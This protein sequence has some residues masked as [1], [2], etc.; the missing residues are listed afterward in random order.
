M[1]A[2]VYDLYISYPDARPSA[3]ESR[4]QAMVVRIDPADR[5]PEGARLLSRCS[6][7]AL[8]CMPSAPDLLHSNPDG[9]GVDRDRIVEPLL[10]AREAVVGI[11]AR[12]RSERPWSPHAELAPAPPAPELKQSRAPAMRLPALLENMGLCAAQALPVRGDL[13][14]VTVAVIDRDFACLERVANPRL[15]ALTLI[16]LERS[17]PAPANTQYIGHGTAMVLSLLEASACRV[18]PYQVG[19][20]ADASYD[21]LG[22]T[23][24]TMA[25]A[26]ACE[27]G[28]DLI[29]IAKNWT[30]LGS[31]RH[32]RRVMQEVSRA[33]RNGRGVLVIWSSG[34]ASQTIAGCSSAAL[35]A[36]DAASQPWGLVVGPCDA[37]GAWGRRAGAP[38]GRLGPA[39]DLTARCE[40]VGVRE[41]ELSGFVDD[42]SLAS[43]LVAAT[44]A[45]MLQR[46]PRLSAG[47]LRELLCLSAARPVRID[48]VREGLGAN[49]ADE[50][51]RSG[52]N[53]KVGHGTVH[54]VAA[55]LA[56][57]DPVCAALVLAG[58]PHARDPGLKLAQNFYIS[59][60]GI[61]APLAR[62]YQVSWAPRL[63][64]ALLDS[65]D[66]RRTALWAAR[67]LVELE[68]APAAH[69]H[70]LPHHAL[71]QRVLIALWE[72]VEC[73]ATGSMPTAAERSG[74]QF[75]ADVERAM[76]RADGAG[77]AAFL[78]RL[79]RT[80]DKS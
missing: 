53:F 41:G 42:T 56:A 65:R 24:L 63:V 46:N 19:A 57:L 55:S 77:V 74:A 52:H 48:P 32:L 3:E 23:H 20:R 2:P 37:S 58:R 39:I 10:A 16:D 7:L 80:G 51:D 60:F 36:D 68:S 35:P 47:Q 70:E 17:V 64:C 54:P 30:I 72:G 34:D 25:I 26:R 38:I 9:W 61:D 31:P 67:H 75:A 45:V 50:W 33:G 76:L 18:R 13:E 79:V 27:D 1:I 28:A 22:A 59:L 49:G 71:V 43:A 6:G 21:Y 11:D 5:L 40:P 69:W 73:S 62:E 44:A 12:I 8:S 66:V 14:R 78:E 4:Y 15:D 29:L